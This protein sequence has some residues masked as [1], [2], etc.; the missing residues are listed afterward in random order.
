MEEINTTY[1]G[2]MENN[3]FAKSANYNSKTPEN[4]K[5]QRLT[6]ALDTLSELLHIEFGSLT[7]YFHQG[8]WSPKIEIKR[9][10]LKEIE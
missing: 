1:E 6:K 2:K 3:K 5:K 8:K 7:V 10:I 9:N 4:L